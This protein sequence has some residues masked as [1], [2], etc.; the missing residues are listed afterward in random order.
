MVGII[1]LLGIICPLVDIGLNVGCQLP[2]LPLLPTALL[3]VEVKSGGGVCVYM[4]R[5]VQA[6]TYILLH[7]PVIGTVNI[8]QLGNSSLKCLCVLEEMRNDAQLS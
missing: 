3:S 5:Q 8:C 7:W 6:T 2:P 4:G 1:S